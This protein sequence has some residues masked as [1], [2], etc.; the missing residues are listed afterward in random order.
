[1][2]VERPKKEAHGLLEGLKMNVEEWLRAGV[3]DPFF[4]VIAYKESLPDPLSA[5]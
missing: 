1:M 4:A 3:C 5:P 2:Q